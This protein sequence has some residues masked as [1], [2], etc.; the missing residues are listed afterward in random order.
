M[1]TV[2]LISVIRCS[3]I[4]NMTMKES[5]TSYIH[6]DSHDGELGKAAMYDDMFGYVL[7]K[8]WNL[9]LKQYTYLILM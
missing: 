4:S 3:D 8:H 2:Y 9:Y 1:K 6:H 7:S 5:N